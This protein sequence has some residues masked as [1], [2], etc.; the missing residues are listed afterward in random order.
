M[1]LFEIEK[2]TI[3][4]ITGIK[5]VLEVIEGADC[6]GF[7]QSQSYTYLNHALLQVLRGKAL[8]KVWKNENKQVVVSKKD[9]TSDDI[10]SDLYW[11]VHTA[12]LFVNKIDITLTSEKINKQFIGLDKSERNPFEI[13]QT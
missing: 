8:T 5:V 1:E 2:R 6:H 13:R 12:W 9:T 11:H 7:K 10:D 3:D 4:N